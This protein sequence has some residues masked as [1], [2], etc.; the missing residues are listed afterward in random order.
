LTA[1]ELL[2]E[3]ET[4]LDSYQT[5]IARA[6]DNRWIPTVP[7]LFVILT[8][9]RMILQPQH[10]KY[11]EP[12]IIPARYVTKVEPL[13][14]NFYQGVILHL[15]TGH[16]IGMFIASNLRDKFED[17]VRTM[18]VPLR[19]PRYKFTF[20]PECVERLISYLKESKTL[21]E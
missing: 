12:A 18:M 5:Q 15:K 9:H 17:E 20:D 7:P 2:I 1:D 4:L 8:D 3:G 10:R 21:G 14:T 13:N 16:R 19:Q 11:H 6:S